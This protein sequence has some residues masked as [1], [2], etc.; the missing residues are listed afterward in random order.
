MGKD[1]K[2]HRY[3]LMLVATMRFGFM[4][5]IDAMKM[6]VQACRG[7]DVRH[8]KRR[9][10]RWI[11][12]APCSLASWVAVGSTLAAVVGIQVA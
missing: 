3:V 6:S 4:V 8:H 9:A 5:V 12:A 10:S 2:V 7:D 1:R 11:T